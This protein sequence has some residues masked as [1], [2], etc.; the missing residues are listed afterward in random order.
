[1]TNGAFRYVRHPLYLAGILSYLGLAI[2]TFSLASLALVLGIFIFYDYIAGYEER[3]L[4]AKF[5]NKYRTY[6]HGTGKWVPR[7]ST[8]RLSKT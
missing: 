8:E 7:I 5:G 1:V 2:S 4:E 6:K 3:L